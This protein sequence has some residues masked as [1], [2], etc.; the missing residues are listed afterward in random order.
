[1]GADMGH[2]APP[3]FTADALDATCRNIDIIQK[4]F[5]GVPFYIENIA[6]LFR[7]R[8]GRWTRRNS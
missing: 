3:P 7:F 5:R 2:F 4:H 6:Y 8:G 1:M